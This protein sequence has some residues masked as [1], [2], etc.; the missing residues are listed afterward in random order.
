M[1]L[2]VNITEEQSGIFT[3]TPSGSIDSETYFELEKKLNPILNPS[4]K[5]I[6]FDMGEVAYISSMGLGVILKTKSFMGKNNASIVI[7]NLQ[8]QVKK[9]FDILKALPEHIFK[10]IEEVDAYI[11]EIQRKEIEKERHC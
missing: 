6:V 3:V 8:P 4:T 11:T 7:S 5:L 2:N 10:N 1:P 9:V